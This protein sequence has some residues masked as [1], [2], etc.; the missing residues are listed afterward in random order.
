MDNVDIVIPWVDGHDVDWLNK[1]NKYLC[2]ANELQKKC[3]VDSR[4]RVGI[5]LKYWFRAVEQCMP[6]VNKIFFVTDGQ[7]PHFLNIDNPKLR[8][9]F[10]E[11]FIPK[12][13]LPTFNSNTIEMNLF[14]IEDLSENFILFNDD[15]FPLEYMKKE[16]F[17]KNGCVCDEAVERIFAPKIREKIVNSF[18]Y[19]RVNNMAIINKH[20]NKREVQKKYFSKWFNIKYGKNIFRNICM[21]Y[22]YTFDDFSNRHLANSFKKKPFEE[23]WKQEYELC[24]E[25]SENKFRNYS[26]VSQYLAQAWQLCSGKFYPRKT[27]GKSFLLS[28]NNYKTVIKYI[29]GKKFNIICLNDSI[30]LSNYNEIIFEIETAI[31]SIYPNKSSYEL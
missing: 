6:W 21:S 20:F 9:V 11:D 8:V 26:D 18:E 1:K 12:K 23:I 16:Y 31:N 2:N 27:V 3:A 14:R 22:F 29:K 30:E 4:Y 5:D 15:I 13:Y 24:D 17:F 25:G 19:C 7:I 28:Q 10:H